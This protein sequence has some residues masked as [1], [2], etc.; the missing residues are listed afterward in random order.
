MTEFVPQK[1]QL[2]NE[3]KNRIYEKQDSHKTYAL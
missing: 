3:T 2:R 1:R